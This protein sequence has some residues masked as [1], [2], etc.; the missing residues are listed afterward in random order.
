MGP[1]PMSV[2]SAPA[3]TL[4]PLKKRALIT[5]VQPCT[6]HSLRPAPLSTGQDADQRGSCIVLHA[7]GWWGKKLSAGR[8]TR[9]VA[10]LTQ[11]QF[12]LQPQLTFATVKDL[13][14]GRFAGRKGG[15]SPHC[16][17][18]SPHEWVL[19]SCT[20]RW[21]RRCSC[22]RQ[23]AGSYQSRDWQRVVKMMNGKRS[24]S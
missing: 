14:N 17:A 16:Q 3:R 1:S 15:S 21:G 12:G 7:C 18:L 9:R 4:K 22:R 13:G 2:I 11:R 23:I 5:R 10:N 20:R 8:Q 19:G 24:S 6:L